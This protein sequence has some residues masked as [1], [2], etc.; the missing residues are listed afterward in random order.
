MRMGIQA[1]SISLH[2]GARLIVES[3]SV[4]V[5]PGKVVAL[6]GPNGSGKS[7]IVSAL[8][9]DLPV[10]SGHI[11]IDERLVPEIAIEE[12]AT[13]R[14]VSQQHQRFSLA[15][16]VADVLTMAITKSGSFQ[17]IFESVRALDIGNLVDRKVT[18]LSGGEQQ[19]VSIAMALAQDTPYLLL[20]EPFAAQDVESSARISEHLRKLSQ[21]G[22]AILV[23]A[24]KNERE[25]AWCDELIRL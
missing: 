23:V 9:G 11:H 25:L 15:F 6:L 4:D 24:H 10:S 16:T 8:A 17:S 13:L 12:L 20:D 1:N 5:A 22:K 21:V 18:S 14:A 19:R 7:T 2:R 3:F